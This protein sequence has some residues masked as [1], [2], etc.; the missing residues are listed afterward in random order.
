MKGPA[1]SELPLPWCPRQGRG[2]FTS[3]IRIVCVY[4]CCCCCTLVT[5]I[6]R[7]YS[8]VHIIT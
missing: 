8:N 1:H 4:C 5:D 6:Y 7:S 2:P 3:A